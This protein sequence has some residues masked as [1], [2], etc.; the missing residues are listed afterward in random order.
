MN[1][2]TSAEVVEVLVEAPQEVPEPAQRAA[3]ESLQAALASVSLGSAPKVNLKAAAVR[4]ARLYQQM[5]REDVRALLGRL[6]DDPGL[7]DQAQVPL[8]LTLS[9]AASHV[10]AALKDAK[11]LREG[12]GARLPR[13]LVEEATALRLRMLSV[14]E[15]NLGDDPDV[16]KRL[17]DIRAGVGYLDLAE[18]LN[19]LGMLYQANASTL[20][21]DQHKYRA[22]DGARA[23]ALDAEIVAHLDAE[24][25]AGVAHWTEQAQRLAT[26]LRA[27]YDDVAATGRWLLRHLPAEALQRR[28]PSLFGG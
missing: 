10:S 21:R 22:E 5:Q 14:A 27:T 2:E 11:A 28:F 13:E 20:A 6:P 12:E 4:A 17:A 15:Y 26:L 24:R 23:F 16:A 19:R 25:R 8:L 7:F 1:P 9:A 18:D 3:Y